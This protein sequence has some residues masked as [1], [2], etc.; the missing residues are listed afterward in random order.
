MKTGRSLKGK[1]SKVI[2]S[3]SLMGRD[4]NQ[5]ARISKTPKS[6]K[7]VKAVSKARKR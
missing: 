6:Q 5:L 3:G 7:A 2:G 4:L 1:A